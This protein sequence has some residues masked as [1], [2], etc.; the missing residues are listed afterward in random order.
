MSTL[1]RM[2]AFALLAQ[3][4]TCLA[5]RPFDGTDA[6][7]AKAGELEIELGP[8]QWLRES[9]KR[10]LQAPALVAN[11]GLSH[12]HEL[13]IEG[14]HEIALDREAGEPRSA[15]VDN[16]AFIKQVLRPGVLQDEPGVSIATEYGLLLPEVNG[17]HGT[18]VSVAGIVSQR[19]LAATIHLNAQFARTR[20][21][22][23]DVFLG[24][25]LEGPIAWR[26]RPVAELFTER[27]RGGPRIDSLLLGAI[28]GLRDGLSFDAGLRSA[29]VGDEAVHELR[30]GLTWAFSSKGSE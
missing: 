2:M 27:P 28:W 16:G 9:G 7:V 24:T 18:G 11:F 21:H 6:E 8:L 3:A 23:P 29:R 10:F 26:V 15:L 14:R 30:L 20:E 1:R 13:V 25:I 19:W 22:E 17:V 12:E 5:Y 4:S